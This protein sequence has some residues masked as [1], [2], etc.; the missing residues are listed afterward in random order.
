MKTVEQ[1]RHFYSELVCAR[2]EI[3]DRR[4]ARAFATVCR[5]DFMG[6][7]P[8]KVSVPGGYLD[9]GTDNPA[10]LYQDLVFAI[11]PEERINNGEPSLHAVCLD[12]L[13]IRSG[14]P[15]LHIG[16]GNGYY[17]AILAELVGNSDQLHAIEVEH[18]LAEEAAKYLA[19]RWN[20]SVSCQSGAEGPLPVSDIIYVNAGATQPLFAWLEALTIGGRLLFPLTPGLGWGAMLLVT[21]QPQGFDARFITRA[22]FIPYIGGQN[23]RDRRRL[24]AAFG[25][26]SWRQVRS[27]RIDERPTNGDCWYSGDG[28]WLSTNELE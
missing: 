18:R 8:W 11:V 27:L 21:R 26:S 3:A 16:I 15:A 9:T 7:G 5:E 22:R 23:E 25:D 1:L 10:V 19:I 2:A 6:P 14:E 24:A 28:W 13:S 12:A 17:T 4:V 20:V